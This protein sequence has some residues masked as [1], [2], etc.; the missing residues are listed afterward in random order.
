M[1]PPPIALRL[2]IAAVALG[3]AGIAAVMFWPRAETT[4]LTGY[5]EGESLYLAAPASGAVSR[6][7]VERGQRVAAGDL[8]FEIDPRTAMAQLDQA[9]A[10]A[11]AAAS[12]ADDALK[13]QRPEELG[14]IAAQRES[15]RALLAQAEADYRRIETLTRQG[16]YAPARLD[17]ARAARDAARAQHE[18]ARR[19]LDVAELG[20][21][22]DQAAAARAEA[23][24]ADAGQR[25]ARVRAGLMTQTAP[26]A[27]RVEDV[28]FRPG[29]W[30][31][32]SSPVIA[33]LPDDRV[34]VRVFAPETQLAAWRPGVRVRIRC[35]GCQPQTATITYVS[36]RPEFSPP[37]I[38]NRGN[39]ERLVFLVEATP[40]NPRALAPG[41]PVDVELVR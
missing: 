13:G 14:V 24:A 30:A 41:Q 9:G 1:K 40:E 11:Q 35:D 22:R 17:Q 37:V 25:E 10:A 34:K 20:A 38:Y 23:Q 19:R 7:G 28:F 26:V 12:R 6:L 5:I 21:R 8:L 3:A 36:A 27:G 16:I 4:G 15:A 33:L 31:G 39:R 18:E 29:E 2:A 32:A